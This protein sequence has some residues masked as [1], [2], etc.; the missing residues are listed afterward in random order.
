M[1][2]LLQYNMILMEYQHQILVKKNIM[3]NTILYLILISLSVSCSA[4]QYPL[5]TNYRT[6]PNNS[7]I[8]DLNNEYNKFVGTWKATL[9]SN[10]IYL[11]ITK[12]ENRPITILN[13]SYF[14]DVLLIKYE[15]LNG[16]QIIESTKNI[17]IENVGIISMGLEI[18]NSVIF[19][20]NGGKCT[21]GWGMINTEYIDSTHLKW[22]YMPQSTMLT[23][24]NCPDYPAG[25]IK[26]NLPDDPEDIIFTKQ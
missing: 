14:S 23:N 17:N 4:Q 18:D 3:K 1:V 16:N 26:I 21:V 6:I 2:T 10:E 22:N 20:Y 8:K 7:Y 19:R 11:Y 12:Q 15:I 24:L 13:K 5:D 25:G 9:G